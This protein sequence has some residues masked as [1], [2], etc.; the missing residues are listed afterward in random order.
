MQHGPHDRPRRTLGLGSP[1]PRGLA[2]PPIARGVAVS[3]G[4][5]VKRV[6]AD[7]E[8]PSDSAHSAAAQPVHGA[9]LVNLRNIVEAMEAVA[10]AQPVRAATRRYPRLSA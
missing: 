5:G 10:D 6:R 3:G 4:D 8:G 9:L 2:G 1:L 7:L